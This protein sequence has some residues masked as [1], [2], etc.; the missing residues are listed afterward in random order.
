MAPEKKGSWDI[1][2]QM[3]GGADNTGPESQ[4]TKSDEEEMPALVQEDSELDLAFD[5]IEEEESEDEFD[6]HNRKKAQAIIKA[7][8]Q[9]MAKEAKEEGGPSYQPKQNSTP[10]AFYTPGSKRGRKPRMENSNKFRIFSN[11]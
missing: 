6:D 4:E 5:E 11:N 10:H 9:E 2:R 3:Q 8:E 7:S 1:K